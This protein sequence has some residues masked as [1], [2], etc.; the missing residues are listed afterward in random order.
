MQFKVRERFG[1]LF[2]FVLFFFFSSVARATRVPTW[3]VGL[4]LQCWS[5]L[6]SAV[7]LF[8]I[9]YNLYKKILLHCVS[10][11]GFVA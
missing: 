4:V 7:T 5:F 1:F 10:L 11:M 9:A 6:N 2:G 3:M 8:S